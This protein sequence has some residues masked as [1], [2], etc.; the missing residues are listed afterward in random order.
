M[1]SPSAAGL[2]NARIQDVLRRCNYAGLPVARC[3]DLPAWVRVRCPVTDAVLLLPPRLVTA[4]HVR[5]E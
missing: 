4:A 1:L 2:V 5:A 3:V